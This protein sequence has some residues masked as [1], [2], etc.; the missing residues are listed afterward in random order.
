MNIMVGKNMV[1]PAEA[2]HLSS[3]LTGTL[4]KRLVSGHA[5]NDSLDIVDEN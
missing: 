1:W 3:K 4:K 2:L 5:A